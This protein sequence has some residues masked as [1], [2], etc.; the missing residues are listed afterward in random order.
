MNKTVLV[1]AL[2]LVAGCSG[3]GTKSTGSVS[4]TGEPGAQAATVDMRD[5]LTFHPS[6]VDAKVG[7]VTLAVKN[8]GNVPHDL[9]FS[10]P[11]LGKTSTVDGMT[12]QDL[13]VTFTKAGTFA[14]VCTFH[15]GMSGEVVVS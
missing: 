11:S 4:T 8:T 15:S 12:S 1:L 9:E 7:T 13:K 6:E 5:D 3:G 2:V 14:F 10:D